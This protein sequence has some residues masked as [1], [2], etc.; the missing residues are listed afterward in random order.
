MPLP[1]ALA[2]LAQF[3]QFVNVWVVED[4]ARP[5]KTNKLPLDPKTGK[6]AS[7]TD[8][9]TWGSYD[10]AVA[11][12]LP[13]GFVITEASKVWCLDI[14][15][16]RQPDG[17]WSP[18][19]LEL[20]AALPGAGVE[21]SCSGNGLHIWGYGVPPAHKCKNTALGIELYHDAR[22]IALGQPDATGNMW[23]DFTAPLAL[24]AARYFPTDGGAAGT[25]ADWTDGPSADWLG[26]VDDEDLI[27]RA[28]ESTS[29][30]GVFGGKATFEALWTGDAD[31]LARFYPSASDSQAYGQSEADAALALH[32]A[33]WTGKDCDRMLRLMRESGLVRDKWEREDYLRMTIL[34]ACGK[35]AKVCRDKGKVELQRME[36]DA[37]RSVDGLSLQAAA[38]V[39]GVWDPTR[40]K[41]YVEIGK[42]EV[43]SKVQAKTNDLPGLF[44]GYAYSPL[45]HKVFSPAYGTFLR[46]EA[47]NSLFGHVH[48]TDDQGENMPGVKTPMDALLSTGYDV[49]KVAGECFEPSAPYCALVTEG[50]DTNV[51]TY[52]AEIVECVA[53]DAGLF[54]RHM[55]MLLPNAHDR[56]IALSYMA[57]LV[58]F[59]GVKFK[60]APVFQGVEGNGKSLISMVLEQAIGASYTRRP[61]AASLGERFN[62]FME[63]SL[64]VAV[65]DIDAN[66]EQWEAFKTNITNERVPIEK[67]GV[68]ERT[69]TSYT[70]FIFNMN[71]KDGLR[72]SKT[73][74]RICPLFTA[75]QSIADLDRD[76]MVGSYFPD[77]YDW[78]RIGGGFAVV[79][80]FLRTYA[81]PD[82]LN[83]ATKCQRAPETSSTVEAVERGTGNI[84]QEVTEAIESGCV[85]FRG[86]F[87]SSHFL[88][89]LLTDRRLKLSRSRRDSMMRSLG[90]ELHPALLNDRGRTNVVV[91]PDGTRPKLYCRTGSPGWALQTAKAVAETYTNLQMGT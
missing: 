42:R 73:D 65:E 51:N 13:I 11:T 76:G 46:P 48:F 26:S 72:K 54:V 68:D 31:E 77:L 47:F 75:Q 12:G 21:V 55:E 5:G 28:R 78:L 83:P 63:R 14:D 86:D 53:G 52:R 80:H 17:S 71:N 69:I 15:G 50:H 34:S 58:Q 16:A 74:R 49:P 32:L 35:C 7:S 10:E 30:G 19:A 62:P 36:E 41:Q 37:E 27:R 60:W 67:K 40:R 84:E 85:G 90:Y 91:T 9:A 4:P 81:I 29:A 89:R 20:V 61:K 24:V 87:V 3:R 23:Q 6:G 33:F 38:A 22:F 88:D 56:Q 64:L 2:A 59:P 18:L 43:R 1:A 66:M 39:A 8:P 82:E 79:T 25:S 44:Y 70:N 45:L 57:A